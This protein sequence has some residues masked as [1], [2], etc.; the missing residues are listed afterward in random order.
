MLPRSSWAAA[1]FVAVTVL[2]AAPALA[3]PQLVQTTPAAGSTVAP[4]DRIELRFSEPLVGKFTGASLTATRMMMGGQMMDHEMAIGGV[5]AAV[6]PTDRKVLVVTLRQR[7]TPGEYRLDWHA[8][9]T[10]THKVK[11]QLAFTVR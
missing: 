10:D 4:T 1:T 7:L 5:K 9:S 3:H 8:V 11:G 2:A 6:S